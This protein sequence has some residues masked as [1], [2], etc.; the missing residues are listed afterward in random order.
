MIH[1]KH[2]RGTVVGPMSMPPPRRRA[3]GGGR[4]PR[5]GGAGRMVGV[6]LSPEEEAE[7]TDALLPGETISGLLRDGGLELVRRRGGGR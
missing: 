6:R 2:R 7:L 4:K 3:P 1:P 5:A